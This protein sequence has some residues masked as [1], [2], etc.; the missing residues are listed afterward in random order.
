M[1]F[2]ANGRTVVLLACALLSVSVAFGMGANSRRLTLLVTPARHSTLQVAFDVLARENAVLVAYQGGAASTDPV[3]HV[4]NGVEWLKIGLEEFGSLS[5]LRTV[6]SQIVLVGDDEVLPTVLIDAAMASPQGR[7][8]Q[9]PSQDN[10]SV[11]NSLGQLL[12][13]GRSDWAWYA[14]RYRLDL[15]DLNAPIRDRSWYDQ[16]NDFRDRTASPW[17]ESVSTDAIDPVVT[18]DS[19]PVPADTVRIEPRDQPMPEPAPAGIAPAT[20]ITG[21]WDESATATEA[22]IK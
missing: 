8:M 19:V 6:P 15:A 1:K 18:V 4:W 14:A 17:E 3:L 12:D 20:E 9:I 13:F 22:P 21:E 11:I 7:V 10:A 16:P 2:L 5:F